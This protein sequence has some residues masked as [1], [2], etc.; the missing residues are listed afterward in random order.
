MNNEIPAESGLINYDYTN[1]NIKSII[2]PRSI[3][4]IAS[5]NCRTFKSKWKLHELTVYCIDNSIGILAIQEHRIYFDINDGDDVIKRINIGKG[6]YFIH[7]SA[8]KSGAGG[9]GFILSSKYYENIC[10]IYSINARHL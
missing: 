10:G 1:N 6:W 8:S 2:C 7:T 9:V 5:F 3:H 4:N